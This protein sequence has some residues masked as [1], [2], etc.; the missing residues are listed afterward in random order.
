MARLKVPRP[1][2]FLIR[3]H[4]T[5]PDAWKK[6]GKR[7]FFLPPPDFRAVTVHYFGQKFTVFAID[8]MLL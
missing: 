1:A 3:D 7:T 8:A 2:P 4:N 6:R 5:A